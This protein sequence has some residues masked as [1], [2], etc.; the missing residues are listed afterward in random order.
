MRKILFGITSLELGG[1]ERVL[2]DMVNHFNKNYDITILTLY[3]NGPFEKEINKNVKIVNVF[4]YEFNSISS[5]KRKMISLRLLFPWS[6]KR[7]YKKFT[8][9]NYDKVI[10][11]LEGPITTLLSYSKD[12]AW[13]HNDISLVFGNSFISKIKKRFNYSIYKK[14]KKL[15]FVSNHNLKKF[16]EFYKINNKKE[17]IYNYLDNDLVLKKS[18]EKIDF[19]FNSDMINFLSVA[20]LVEQKAIDRLIRIHKKLIDNGYKHRIY[21]V[22]DGP[23]REEYQNLIKELNVEDT[24][25]LL[26]SKT[27]PYP[28]I[29]NSDIFCLLS[30]YEGLPMVLLESMA[31]NKKIFITNTASSEALKNYS[32]KIIA[33]NNEEDIYKQMKNIISGEAKFNMKTNENNFNESI[34][35]SLEKLLEDKND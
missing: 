18:K 13:V 24:F 7:I 6:R 31:L 12:T 35:K 14:Y 29:K 16:E 10:A 11:F 33:E 4:D 1:A 15:I 20:R 9:N 22:G 25:I 23:K 21:I 34:L 2:V 26:L 5:I 27:N 32:S 19:N 30:Y 17:V 8:G 28:Y 3:K